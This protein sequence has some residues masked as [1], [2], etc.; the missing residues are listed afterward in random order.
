MRSRLKVRMA[1]GLA[2][3]AV[4]CFVNWLMEG[5]SS[6]LYRYFLYHVGLPNVWGRLNFVPYV[7]ILVSQ[8]L[9][10]A[11]AIYYLSIFVQWGVAG[12]LISLLIRRDKP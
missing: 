6:P 10:F 2:C 4:A 11:D 9:A 5:E 3:G 7:I 1:V 8:P 12:I